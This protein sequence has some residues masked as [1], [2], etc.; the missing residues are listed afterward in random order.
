MTPN[1]GNGQGLIAKDSRGS[2][3]Q[4]MGGAKRNLFEHNGWKPLGAPLI[5]A[6]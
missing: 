1:S 5:P 4:L 2:Y 3:H 6:S